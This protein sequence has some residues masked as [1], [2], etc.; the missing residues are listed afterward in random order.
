MKKV[1][2]LFPGQGSQYVGMGKELYENI[3]ECKEIFQ[4]ADEVLDMKISD[5]CFNGDKDILNKT[6]NTQPALLT[7]STAILEVLKSKGI[8]A[9]Y[10]AG[11]SLGEY[12]ALVYGGALDFQEAVN[13]VRKRG[14]FM[15]DAVQEGVGGMVAVL[16]LKDEEVLALLEKASIYGK[17]EGANFNCTGQVVVAGENAALDEMLRLVKEKGGKAV[18]LKV[19][20]PF[21]CSML[22]PAAKELEKEL[23]KIEIKPLNRVVYSNLKGDKYEKDDDIKQILRDQVMKPVLFNKIIENILEEGVDTFVEIG[24][25]KTLSGFVKKTNKEV[26]VFNIEDLDSLNRFIKWYKEN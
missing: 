26:N 17:I 24:P 7:V 1:A 11:L 8:N 14:R 3:P 18:R 9:N 15:Q 5:L 12:S 22:E 25:G 10:A 13:L 21:H 19:S 20:A 2:F 23:E 16:N 4:R 6:E